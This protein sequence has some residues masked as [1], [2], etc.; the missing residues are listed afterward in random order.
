MTQNLRSAMDFVTYKRSPVGSALKRAT[1]CFE[2][3]F[4]KISNYYFRAVLLLLDL[5]YN[6]P[7]FQDRPASCSHGL[8]N[9]HVPG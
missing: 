5:R 3:W 7:P 8:M 2:V 9:F 6:P 4:A 1:K